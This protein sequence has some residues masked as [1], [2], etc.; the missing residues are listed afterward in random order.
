MK[1]IGDINRLDPSTWSGTPAAHILVEKIKY[2]RVSRYVVNQIGGVFHFL[3]MGLRDTRKVK[4]GKWMTEH[5]R[6]DAIQKMDTLFDNHRFDDRIP[7]EVYSYA[8]NVIRTECKKVMR[9]VESV[10]RLRKLFRGEK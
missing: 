9:D 1:H 2:Y 4:C 10:D 8:V 5:L 3:H 7:D 6:D